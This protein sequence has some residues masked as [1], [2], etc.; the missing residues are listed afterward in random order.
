MEAPDSAVTEGRHTADIVPCHLGEIVVVVDQV[1]QG[2]S[3]YK[4]QHLLDSYADDF[5][6]ED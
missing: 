2:A 1:R 5:Y 6:T 4:Y 3:T